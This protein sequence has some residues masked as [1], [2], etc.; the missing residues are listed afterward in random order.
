MS[1]PTL[2]TGIVILFVLVNVLGYLYSGGVVHIGGRTFAGLTRR[3]T[4]FQVVAAAGDPEGS[5]P[6]IALG[7]DTEPAL[8]VDLV[9]AD[10]AEVIAL[11]AAPA[12]QGGVED[13]LGDVTAP[14]PL[15]PRTAEA[16]WF[17]TAPEL[18]QA[19]GRHRVGV[20]AVTVEELVARVGASA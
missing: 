7:L 1:S 4:S 6:S 2:V 18:A 15:T 11:P 8:A 16:G 3:S 17:T 10:D 14:I 5:E 20:T 13:D 9:D 19:T 12:P